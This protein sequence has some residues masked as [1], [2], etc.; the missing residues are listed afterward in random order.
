MFVRK[1]TDNQYC[2]IYR[3]ICVD[4]TEAIDG[5]GSFRNFFTTN[6]NVDHNYRFYLLK[7]VRDLEYI[8]E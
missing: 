4:Q 1:F 2:M 8:Y 6:R 5:D 7:D 3:D